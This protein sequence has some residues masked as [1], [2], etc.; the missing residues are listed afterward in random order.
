MKGFKTS[1]MEKLLSVPCYPVG[2]CSFLD[3]GSC[4]FMN[5][6]VMV[7]GVRIA[8]CCPSSPAASILCVYICAHAVCFRGGTSVW[9]HC[10]LTIMEDAELITLG[11]MCVWGKNVCSPTSRTTL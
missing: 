4:S 5:H 9:G 3:A 2:A 1:E 7:L 6:L 10:V 8:A 11:R